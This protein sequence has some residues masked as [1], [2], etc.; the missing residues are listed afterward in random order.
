MIIETMT[1]PMGREVMNAK[2]TENASVCGW[3]DGGR[4]V[5]P[6]RVY[7]EDT[8]AAGIV[9]HANYLRFGERARTEMMRCLG[10]EHRRMMQS[11]GLA[12]AVRSANTEFHHPARLDDPL[13]VETSV[14]EV[15]GASM[16]LAQ[17]VMSIDPEKGTRVALVQISIRLACIDAALQPARLPKPV[18]AALQELIKD[19]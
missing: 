15:G 17:T 6:V 1:G 10:A 13:M 5:Y 18:R 3:F 14:E 4:H 19:H 12:F 2:A 7:Y 11:D 9:Y 8:D 16:R